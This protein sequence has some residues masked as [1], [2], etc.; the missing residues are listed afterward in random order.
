MV[1]WLSLPCSRPADGQNH[2]ILALCLVQGLLKAMAL[3][4]L[5]KACRRPWFYL[6]LVQGLL[7]AIIMVSLAHPT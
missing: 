6:C 1:F 7:A 5:F 4:A 3:A 2:G